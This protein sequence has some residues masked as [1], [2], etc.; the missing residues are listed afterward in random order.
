MK[1]K[2]ASTIEFAD[3]HHDNTTTFHCQLKEGHSGKHKETGDMGYGIMS[4]PYTLTWENDSNELE[5]DEE[6]SWLE[7]S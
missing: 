1:Q 5:D 3:D 2:C 6:P 4:I 7:P